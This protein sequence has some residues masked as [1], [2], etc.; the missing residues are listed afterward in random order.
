MKRKWIPWVIAAGAVVVVIVGLLLWNPPFVQNILGE[1]NQVSSK[2]ASASGSDSKV[3]V[4]RVGS[5]KLTLAEYKA[6]AGSYQQGQIEPMEIIEPWIQQELIYQEAVEIGLD[7][8]DSVQMMLNQLEIQYE[9]SRKQVLQNFWVRK[10]TEKIVV[11]PQEVEAYFN[12]HKDEFL[13]DVKVSQIMVYDPMTAQTIYQQLEGGAGFKKL[14]EQYTQDPLKGDPSDFVSRGSG[15]LTLPM[16]DAIF[17]LEPGEYSK[18][19]ITAE[20]PTFIFKLVDKVKVR[21]DVSYSDYAGY[22]E[23]ML[24]YERAQTELMNKLDSMMNSARQ[25]AD[26]EINLGNLY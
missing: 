25:N 1:S 12:K 19:V 22:I 14:A 23:A 4:A 5:S 16:E 11:T 15:Q 6:I 8:D 24:R 26:F 20:G 21:K 3:V 7:K 13:Y 10:E 18:P 2:S 17:A 9:F